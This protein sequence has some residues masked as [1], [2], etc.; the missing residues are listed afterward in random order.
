MKINVVLQVNIFW[1]ST[2]DINYEDL[3]SRYANK[4]IKL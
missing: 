1:N 3:Q 4:F 2:K